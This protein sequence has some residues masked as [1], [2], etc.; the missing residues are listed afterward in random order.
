MHLIEDAGSVDITDV[1]AGQD[2]DDLG[3]STDEQGSDE[4]RSSVESRHHKGG[5]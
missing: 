2:D 3:D 4:L 1:M 5:E